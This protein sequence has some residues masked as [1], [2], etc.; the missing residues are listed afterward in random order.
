METLELFSNTKKRIDME[1]DEERASK[2]KNV[3]EVQ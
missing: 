3:S 2:W 1:Q